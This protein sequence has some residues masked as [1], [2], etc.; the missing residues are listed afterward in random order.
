MCS[1][2]T[3]PRKLARRQRR[4][5]TAPCQVAEGASVAWIDNTRFTCQRGSCSIAPRKLRGI[6]RILGQSTMN[7][8]YCAEIAEKC[9]FLAPRVCTGWNRSV[10]VAQ[11]QEWHKHKKEWHKHIHK[12]N[13]M[14]HNSNNVFSSVALRFG[15][16]K[17]THH[18]APTTRTYTHR[19][20][21]Y[22][23]QANNQTS[24]QG[25]ASANRSININARVVQNKLN[26]RT[27]ERTKL[28]R[29][30][31]DAQR[32]RSKRKRK[33][34]EAIEG[35]NDRRNEGTKQQRNEAKNA[36]EV[37]SLVVVTALRCCRAVSE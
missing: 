29:S 35:R 8:E 19:V 17:L 3:T 1:D 28:S 12:L 18:T 15:A 32:K 7:C 13:T 14:S 20:F 10:P 9:R 4:D 5:T 25:S 24:K 11:P 27:N 33:Q 34:T 30:Q 31:E 26:E 37:R 21:E 16:H 22:A 36:N 2:R 6:S 23:Q